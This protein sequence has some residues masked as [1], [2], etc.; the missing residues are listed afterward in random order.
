MCSSRGGGN[1]RLVLQ[2][3]KGVE[4]FI[5]KCYFSDMI[6]HYKDIKGFTL[7]EVLITLGIIGVVAALTLPSLISRYKRIYVQSRIDK[8]LSIFS[9]AV[10]LS[11]NE[12]GPSY[13]WLSNGKLPLNEMILPYL[14][15]IKSVPCTDV[16]DYFSKGLYG[17]RLTCHILEDGMILSISDGVATR[18]SFV[19]PENGNIDSASVM[20]L[21]NTKNIKEGIDMFRFPLNSSISKGVHFSS[22]N[23]IYLYKGSVCNE[24]GLIDKCKNRDF[25]Q[26]TAPESKMDYC[27]W[28]IICNGY[29]I[30]NDYP[31]GF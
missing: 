20:L 14:N 29:K 1:L 15:I 30:P 4:K 7:A 3:F 16:N 5:K 25:S 19:S 6:H 2:G 17:K 23:Y 18:Y 28:L 11:E 9:Q 26:I 27:S 22:L 10:K 31:L 21:L 12:N 13:F 8:F 24:S